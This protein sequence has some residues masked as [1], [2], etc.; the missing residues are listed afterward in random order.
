MSRKIK[1]PKQDAVGPRKQF[2]SLTKP[3]SMEDC[4]YDLELQECKEIES[5]DGDTLIV[6]EFKVLDTDT[7]VK[8]GSSVSHFMNPYQKLAEVYFWRDV[9]ALN[10]TLKGKT[11]TKK[12]IAK[13][14]EDHKA[15][16][17]TLLDGDRNGG[18][19]RC[20]IESYTKKDGTPGSQKRFELMEATE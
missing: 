11:I 17:Q 1:P 16:L 7:K 5:K 8:V 14:C 3:E 6:A 13:L 2:K 20:V 15:A 19:C 9:L 18:T 12:R 10:I 4:F